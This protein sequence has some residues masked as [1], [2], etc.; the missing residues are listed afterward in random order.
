MQGCSPAKSVSGIYLDLECD[1]DRARLAQ[2]ELHLADH[3]GKLVILDEVHRAPHLFP[4]LRRLPPWHANLDKR[5]VK[6]PKVYARDSGSVH[7]MLDTTSN[8]DPLSHMA[9]GASW[10]GFVIEIKRSLRRLIAHTQTGGAPG[11]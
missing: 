8:E 9:L 4:V 1:G 10:K 3:L 7:G 5:L 2:P 6:S 11:S